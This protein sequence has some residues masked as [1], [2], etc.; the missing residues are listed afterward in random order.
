[1]QVYSFCRRNNVSKLKKS[2]AGVWDSLLLQPH[3]H[4]GLTAPLHSPPELE[5]LCCTFNRAS[6]A[7]RRRYVVFRS[8]GEERVKAA[9]SH[10]K[11]TTRRARTKRPAEQMAEL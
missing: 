1:M 7:Q 8:A 9:V 3:L 10:N 4:Q 2:P 5:G 11:K 6:Q